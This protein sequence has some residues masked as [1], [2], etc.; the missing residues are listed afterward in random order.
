MAET[1]GIEQSSRQVRTASG[2]NIMMGLWLLIAPWA[3]GYTLVNAAVWNSVLIGIAVALVAV[4]RIAMPLRYEGVSWLNF[5]LGVWLLFAPFLLGFADVGPAMWNSMVS[6]ALILALS[7]W[8]ATSG[9][10]VDDTGNI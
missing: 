3:L 10:A 5:A 9:R 4:L 2:L 1:Y 6:G 7:A 8:A